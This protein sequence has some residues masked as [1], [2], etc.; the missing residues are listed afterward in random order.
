MVF[1]M[2][3]VPKANSLAQ[4]T[5]PSDKEIPAQPQLKGAK[6]FSTLHKLWLFGMPIICFLLHLTS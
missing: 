3:A 6:V 1:S 4:E 5:L 2:V